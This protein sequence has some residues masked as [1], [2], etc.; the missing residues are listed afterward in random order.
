MQLAHSAQSGYR[1]YAAN[2]I[3]TNIEEP[4]DNILVQTG[5]SARDGRRGMG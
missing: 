4:S 3:E 1:L 2:P 5:L